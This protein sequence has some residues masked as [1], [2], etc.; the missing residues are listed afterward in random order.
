M[1]ISFNV[2]LIHRPQA[3]FTVKPYQLTFLETCEVTDIRID[4]GD[5][6]LYVCLKIGVLHLFQNGPV[7]FFTY[8]HGLFG[9]FTYRYLRGDVFGSPA[10][11]VGS[12]R[13]LS[14]A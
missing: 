10:S 5:H 14:A 1:I 4:K 7:F 6:P 2:F 3:L 9:L 11:R 13:Q 8:T 12:Q